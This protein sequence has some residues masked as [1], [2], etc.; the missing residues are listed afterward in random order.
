VGVPAACLEG[1]L[2]WKRGTGVGFPTPVPQAKAM[3][4]AGGARE[5]ETG[6]LPVLVG[7]ILLGSPPFSLLHSCDSPLGRILKGVLQDERG[8]KHT[9]VNA[10]DH[11]FV[12]RSN[13]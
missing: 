13:P 6:L 2:T 11:C 5:H 4:R 12:K 3:L 7:R 9:K 1:L 8:H 10:I